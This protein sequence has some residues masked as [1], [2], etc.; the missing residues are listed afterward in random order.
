VTGRSFFVCG[1]LLV[2]FANAALGDGTFQPTRN[3]K[4]LVWNNYPRPG[5]EATWS[6][7]RDREGYAR[8]FGTLIWYTT[9]QDE[10]GS[11]K[12]ALYARYWGNMIRGKFNGAVNVHSKKKT[13]YAIFADG[14]RMTHWAA[15]RAPSRITRPA[16]ADAMKKALAA[17]QA[18]TARAEQASN[19]QR[20]VIAEPEPPAEGP[21]A[22]KSEIENQR[23][24]ISEQRPGQSFAK[25]ENARPPTGAEKPQIDI[26]DSLRILVWPPS[27]LRPRRA[28][29]AGMNQEPAPPVARAHLTKEEV[30]DL[31]DTVARARGYDPAE[32]Q[33]PEPAYDPADRAWSILYDQKPVDGRATGKHFSVAVGDEMKGTAL[34]PAR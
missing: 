31:A 6:G 3:G 18:E 30:V 7:G 5:D 34:V 25:L 10:S 24:E 4:T 32:Y 11:A 14:A 20:A 22:Q 19:V 29:L 16:F 12:P 2:V 1:A 23:S 15:G 28:S 21:L 9:E 17:S 8:G 33:R 26:D 27:T 13:H